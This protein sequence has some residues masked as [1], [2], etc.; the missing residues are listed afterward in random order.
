MKLYNNFTSFLFIKF[1]LLLLAISSYTFPWAVGVPGFVPKKPLLHHDL[2]DLA[3]RYNAGVVQF[4]DNLPLHLLNSRQLAS[5]KTRASE[6][7]LGFEVGTRRLTKEN[8]AA[9]LRL[10]VTLES[11]FVRMII[12]DGDYQPSFSE[13]IRLINASVPALK[14]ANVKLA[15]ENHDRFKSTELRKMIIGT[16][17]E[18]VGVCLD[19]ANSIGSNEGLIETMS[20]LMPFTINL[21]LKDVM[22]KRVPHKMGFTVEGTAAGAGMLDLAWVVRELRKSGQCRSA[23]V[24]LWTTPLDD[25]QGTIAR[26]KM[27]AEQSIDYIKQLLL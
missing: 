1:Y 8:L 27:L 19:T 11:P 18:W 16:D 15:L 24:E 9:Y 14:A 21:H 3:I 22:I 12:D 25:L 10:A 13:I 23:V 17:P 4:G 26:E 6:A 5:L 20:V 2:V 7:K